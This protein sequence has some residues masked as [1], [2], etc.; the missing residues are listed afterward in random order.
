MPRKS[1]ISKKSILRAA[2]IVC[3]LA[4]TL[5]L[6]LDWTPVWVGFVVVAVGGLCY[7]VIANRVKN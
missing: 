2:G 5:S 3:A 1:R 4:G 7:F 6:T